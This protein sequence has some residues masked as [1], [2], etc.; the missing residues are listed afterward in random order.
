M[1]QTH[2]AIS[3]EMN[4]ISHRHQLNIFILKRLP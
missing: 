2:A 3:R 4:E 1:A